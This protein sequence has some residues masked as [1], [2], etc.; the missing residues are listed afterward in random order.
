VTSTGD[1]EPGPRQG[2]DALMNDR[3]R[4]IGP[5]AVESGETRGASRLERPDRCPVAT[6][7]GERI[8]TLQGGEHPTPIVVR[9]LRG[10]N[11]VTTNPDV[12]F[13][14]ATDRD[15]I[16]VDGPRGQLIGTPISQTVRTVDP[17]RVGGPL[18]SRAVDR[19]REEGPGRFPVSAGGP[20]AAPEY[21]D[22]TCRMFRRLLK[23][24]HCRGPGTGP[25]LVQRIVDRR[26]GRVW[27]ESGEVTG[28]TLSFSNPRAP[29]GEGA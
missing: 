21:G 23:H 29:R 9:S 14:P 7:E 22:R 16:H 3:A 19:S 28:W 1:D 26:G 12:K 8:W 24:D 2:E 25:A 27:P 13:L 20:G 6:G 5:S 10:E 18:R 4:L 11:A 17:D 15:A